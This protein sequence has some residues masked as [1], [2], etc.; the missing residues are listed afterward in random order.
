MTAK[1]AGAVGAD[2]KARIIDAAEEVVLRDGVARLT[3][4]AAA[5]EAGLSKGGV[6]Y[7]FPTRDALV[8]GMVGKIIQEFDAD[9][10]YLR[11]ADGGPGSFTRAYIRAT[12]EPV[13]PRPD[14]EDR[15]GA[16]VIAA[17]A[18]Q[19][20]LLAPLQLASDRWQAQL[21]DDGLDATVATVVRLAC[22]GLWLCDLFGLAP[23]T[24]ARRTQVGTELERLTGSSS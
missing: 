12:M 20:A 16:A 22:D 14:R 19:P 24:A 11:E 18:A 5:V 7:H 17:A 1:S 6:L 3:L 13:S 10:E 8:A 21:E 15:L 9:I 4:E 2:T 23:P